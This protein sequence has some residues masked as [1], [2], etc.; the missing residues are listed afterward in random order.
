M[1]DISGVSNFFPTVN[2]G[3]TTATASS[4]LSG[5]TVVPLNTV[6]GL[7]NG[8]IF[9]GII[10]PGGAS[11]QVFT[12]TV[13]TSGSRITGVV[14]TRGS[15]VDH[16]GG[17][18]VVDYVTGTSYNMISAGMR[19]AHNQSGTLKTNVLLTNPKLSTDLLD[20][21]G[22]ELI[23]TVAT[24]SAVNEITVTNKA[25][26]TGPTIAATGGDTNIHLNL[27]PKGNAEVQH[28]GVG[29]FHPDWTRNVEGLYPSSTVAGTWG[30][31][32]G[33]GW[34]RAAWIVNNTHALNDEIAYKIWMEAGTY[35]IKTIYRTGTDHG[36][37]R[38]QIA[39]STIT[40]TECYDTTNHHVTATATGF[41][42]VAPNSY[43]SFNYKVTGKNAS[44]SDYFAGLF[45]ISIVRTA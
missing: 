33:T 20:V 23:K 32:V 35:T 8:S 18:T 19:V 37:V 36:Q 38:W 2:E 1:S 9:V 30:E 13:D 21:N 4:I 12:G 45:F 15:N 39:G 34:Y 29:P 44:S 6:S 31:S 41:A 40:T 28:N 24:S 5:A 42:V 27:V 17:S 22:N 14:W 7:T 10:N 3:F 25:T 16:S 11:Q 43:L 26:G